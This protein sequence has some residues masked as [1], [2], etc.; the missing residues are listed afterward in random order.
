MV[1]PS[2]V[3]PSYEGAAVSR[4]PRRGLLASEPFLLLAVVLLVLYF[5]REILMPFALALTLNF[6]FTPVVSF[7]QR[8]RMARIPAVLLVVMM[9]AL[10]LGGVGWIVSTQ[11]IGVAED[12]GQYRLNIHNKLREIHAPTSGPVGKAFESL[13]I[14]LQEFSGDAVAPAGAGDGDTSVKGK[15]SSKGT[16]I[17]LPGSAP[18]PVTVVIP[19][20][21]PIRELK[22]L[23]VPVGKP[24]GEA[25]IVMIFTIYMLVN[26]E[27][28]R[29]RLLLLAG[30][31]H[32]NLMTQA[33]NDAAERISRYLIMNFLVNA[34]YGFV[35]GCGLYL[36]GVPNATLWGAVAGILR[37]VPY[38]GTMMGAML[39]LLFSV[40]IFNTWWHPLL[41]L[42][43]FMTIEMVLS[44]FLEPLIYG[45]H[46]GISP[47]ALVTMAILW[48][49]IWGWPGLVLSTPL[50]VCLIVLGRYVP[51]MSFLHT[52]LGDEVAMAPEA[53]FYERLLAL[54]QTEAHSIAEQYLEGKQ[55]IELYDGVLLPSLS[56]AEQDRHKGALDEVRTEFVFHSVLELIAELTDYPSKNAANPPSL[57]GGVAARK[58]PIV[59]VSTADEADEI[60]ATMLA[61]LLEQEGNRTMMLPVAALSPEI[62]ARLAEEPETMI[63]ISALPPF[64]FVQSRALCQRIREHLP[65][66]RI[67]I[68][69][70]GSGAEPER[71]RERF[72]RTRPDKVVLNL[73]SAMEQIREWQ[74][75]PPLEHAVVMHGQRD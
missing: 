21:G 66:N 11:L 64:A 25:V 54:D 6:L 49:M 61:Q 75:T 31:G 5:A 20:K 38:V 1:K 67:V 71:T 57:R 44:N 22:D 46:T 16:T 70:W 69:L 63:C 13:R 33:L 48:T 3:T 55:L 29:N 4:S 42:A 23:L 2:T 9:A 14:I 74:H 37:V 72:G 41:V 60:A 26:R 34:G 68:C 30:M 51:Q 10:V 39:P 7:L 73:T 59:C 19:D 53:K 35:F 45:S 15:G 52:L 12:L 43:L 24:L 27:D 65:N 40:I 8:L 17:I 32:M 36:I 28:L 50:T 62:L 56:L 47:L 58:F 18:T